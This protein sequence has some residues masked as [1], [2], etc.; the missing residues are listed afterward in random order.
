MIAKEVLALPKLVE[1]AGV[2]QTNVARW[3]GRYI[4]KSAY[5]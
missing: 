5:L 3:Y 1:Q 4:G 2:E